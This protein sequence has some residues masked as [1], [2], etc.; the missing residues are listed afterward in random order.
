MYCATRYLQRAWNQN[1]QIVGPRHNPKVHAHAYTPRT[2][3]HMQPA[4]HPTPS[5][6]QEALSIKTTRQTLLT[7]RQ[8]LT[9][10][11]ASLLQSALPQQKSKV[12]EQQARRAKRKKKVRREASTHPPQA[13]NTKS[14]SPHHPTNSHRNPH[15]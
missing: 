11:S 7:H 15:H 6:S 5:I 14:D 1:V 2:P 8:D 4:H 13:P 9:H 3:K 12:D 10:P